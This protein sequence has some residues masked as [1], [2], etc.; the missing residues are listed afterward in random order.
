MA[1]FSHRPKRIS[2]RSESEKF[3]R[4]VMPAAMMC[5]PFGLA[6]LI[7]AG[8][9]HLIYGSLAVEMLVLGGAIFAIPGVLVVYR[10]V[11]GH[12]NRQLDEP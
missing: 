11:R 9:A 7:G 8:L 2:R 12:F 10:F 5:L 6:V 1:R 3:E 4:M